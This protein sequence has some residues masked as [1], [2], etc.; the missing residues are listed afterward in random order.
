MFL[1]VDDVVLLRE[2]AWLWGTH[3]QLATLGLIPPESQREIW[4]HERKEMRSAVAVRLFAKKTE[5]VRHGG[6][7][8][9][10]CF[11]DPCF[12][13]PK[14]LEGMARSEN[15]PMERF[16]ELQS[17]VYRTFSGEEVLANV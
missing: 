16:E 8:I 12:L 5:E 2:M 7:S 4:E 17:F 1:K 3:A 6:F 10:V 15:F 11:A 9:L 14:V 13:D